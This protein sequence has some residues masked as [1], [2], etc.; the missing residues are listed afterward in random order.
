MQPY[1]MRRLFSIALVG[2]L[3]LAGYGF[4]SI[5]A[6]ED[7]TYGL[8]MD[9]VPVNFDDDLT[10]YIDTQT[11][12]RRYMIFNDNLVI[13]SQYLTFYE[14]N[15][16]YEHD[17]IN[18]VVGGYCYT[19]EIPAQNATLDTITEINRF[20]LSSWNGTVTVQRPTE[21]STNRMEL[22]INS[23]DN[24]TLLVRAV[25]LHAGD[26]YKVFVDGEVQGWRWV[27]DYQY[28]DY[29]YTGDWSTHTVV[30]QFTGRAVEVP[31]QY[32]Y[33]IEAM[34]CMGIFI[35]VMKEM[36]LPLKKKDYRPEEI[37]KALIKATMFIVVGMALV[38]V[39]FRMFVG[40]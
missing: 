39:V 23:T 5:L 9:N 26:E 6:T 30:F 27:N 35:A 1:Y 8:T 13:Q 10:L 3:A 36:V 16:S 2:S 7:I 33:L 15:N 22:T 37:T 31:A 11:N 18:Y 19:P 25:G 40:V 29:N 14:L 20:Q 4:M 21:Y 34:L 12:Y 32:L 17:D 24:A 28:F 38:I